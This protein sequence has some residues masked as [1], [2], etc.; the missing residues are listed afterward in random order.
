MPGFEF[1]DQDEI[2]HIN[3]VMNSGILMRYNFDEMRNNHWK[4]KALEQAIIDKFKI[5]HI[6]LA[7]SGTSAIIKAINSLGN[8]ASYI[9]IMSSFTFDMSIEDILL[10]D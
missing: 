3:D 4:A 5:D 1:F 2:K 8:G 10:N 7:I 6:H 9:D